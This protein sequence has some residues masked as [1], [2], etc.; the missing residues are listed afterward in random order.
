MSRLLIPENATA[1]NIEAAL[2]IS[3]VP[4]DRI[5]DPDY[6][7]SQ[8]WRN[9]I[10]MDHGIEVR[11]EKWTWKRVYY[12]YKIYVSYVI[13]NREPYVWNPDDQDDCD[14]D[15]PFLRYHI[16]PCTD[17]TPSEVKKTITE[18]KRILNKTLKRINVKYECALDQ[19]NKRFMIFM[20]IDT[21]FRGDFDA[22]LTLDLMNATTKAFRPGEKS[23]YIDFME[24]QYTGF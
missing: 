3:R 8:F 23:F 12:S 16:V 1:E 6:F 19:A 20:D 2:V 9:R 11:P 10:R 14:P 22:Q 4:T 21:P 7:Y 18:A 15:N 13:S 5:K 17:L 24:T